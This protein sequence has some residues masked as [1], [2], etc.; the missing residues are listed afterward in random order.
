MTDTGKARKIKLFQELK[1]D[2]LTL[3]LQPGADLDEASLSERHGLSRT[4]LREVLRELA[5]EGYVE[6]RDNRGARVSDMSFTTLRE[7]FQAAPMI[8]GAI[9]Q[10]AA[11]NRTQAQ[12][13]ELKSAQN[14]FVSALRKGSVAERTLANNRFHELTGEMA[15]NVYLLPS[16]KRL[17]ID[18]ARIGMTFYRPMNNEMADKLSEAS[19]QHDAI[20]SAIE[21][22]DDQQAVELAEK[23]WNLSRGQIELFVTPSGI[24]AS[25]GSVSRPPKT[26]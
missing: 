15:G 18:H 10:L 8:Y 6:L 25:L 11:L 24:E 2:I 5:G 13:D 1:T 16:F 9:L 20:I 4:P 17:L 23:H 14:D 26:A 7:F 21:A 19:L 12:I 3:G 22:M